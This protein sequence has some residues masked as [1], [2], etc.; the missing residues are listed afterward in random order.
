MDCDVRMTR[1]GVALF[2]IHPV[3]AHIM[4]FC[5]TLPTSEMRL[6][7]PRRAAG[8]QTYP[9]MLDNAVRGAIVAGEDHFG[10]KGE[11][12]AWMQL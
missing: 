5:R 4:A 9:G 8:E 12:E 6:W 11:E 2:G 3:G 7:I 1:G 10:Q